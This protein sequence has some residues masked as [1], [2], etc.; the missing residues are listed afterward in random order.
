M[1]GT[2]TSAAK[3]LEGKPPEKSSICLLK[4]NRA[5]NFTPLGSLPA[6]YKTFPKE[7]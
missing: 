3:L 2:C 7:Y 6:V 4:K 1:S 5:V